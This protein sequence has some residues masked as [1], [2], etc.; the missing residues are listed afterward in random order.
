MDFVPPLKGSL[1]IPVA[2]IDSFEGQALWAGGGSSRGSSRKFPGSLVPAAAPARTMEVSG[3]LV[4]AAA[5]ASVKVGCF[6]GLSGVVVNNWR[7]GVVTH[8]PIAGDGEKGGSPVTAVAPASAA[9]LA[10]A[11]VGCFLRLSGVVVN[12]RRM[13]VVTHTPIVGVGKA[14]AAHNSFSPLSGLGSGEDL[15]FG[16][17]DDFMVDSGD[18]GG[19]WSS[20]NAE[21]VLSSQVGGVELL[22]D[23]PE[24]LLSQ[25]KHSVVNPSGFFHGE[26]ENGFLEC[27]PFS[28]WD[29]NGHKEL[30]VI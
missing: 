5:L 7:M 16:E 15:C 13:G 14:D 18:K 8:T 2:L 9:E 17:R 28:K 11:T 21:H 1:V 10:N 27:S 19:D 6:P 30:E 24:H 26:D 20:P 4:T 12:S 29:P 22:Q 25:W 23:R 3:S